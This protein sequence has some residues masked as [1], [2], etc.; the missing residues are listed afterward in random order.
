ME[1]PTT[2]SLHSP[3][4]KPFEHTRGQTNAQPPNIY[5][6][7]HLP[8]FPTN[9]YRAIVGHTTAEGCFS[10]FFFPG[11]KVGFFFHVTRNGEIWISGGKEKGKRDQ[12]KEN[13]LWMKRGRGEIFWQSKRIG[14]TTPTPR[15]RRNASNFQRFEIFLG[16]GVYFWGRGKE[17][18]SNLL[19]VPPHTLAHIRKTQAAIKQSDIFFEK[20]EIFHDGLIAETWGK[21]G[22]NVEIRNSKL[23]IW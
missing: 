6:L 2:T 15:G 16:K 19:L 3:V 5:R 14:E 10:R 13:C 12:S 17:K 22:E 4:R 23:L 1:L 9:V 8:R 20:R 11:I 18:L 21:R 7:I